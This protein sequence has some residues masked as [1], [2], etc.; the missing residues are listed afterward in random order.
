MSTPRPVR[1]SRPPRRSFRRVESRL[2]CESLEGRIV[3]TAGVSFDA[4]RGILA[5]MGSETADT[6]IV[7]NDGTNIVATLTTGTG[8]ITRSYR[9]SA[10]KSIAFTGLGGDDSFINNTA[11]PSTAS[12]GR[13]NDSLR[14][15]SG[16]DNLIGGEG[17]D[18]IQGNKGDDVLQGA[19]GNDT[20]IG[21]AGADRMFGGVGDDT[22]DG[23]IGDDDV[24]GGD[25]ADR[26]AGATG[27]DRLNGGRGDDWLDG[28]AGN[29]TG[30]GDEGNDVVRGGQGDDSLYGGLDNDAL[31]GD[32]GIDTVE[33]EAGDDRLDGG[34]GDDRLVGGV[35][36]DACV[37]VEDGFDDWDGT[38]QEDSDGDR[39]GGAVL[40]GA[41][42]FDAAGLAGIT[43]TVLDKKDR[44]DYSV[45][46]PADGQL[47][48]ELL[49]G[50]DGTWAKLVLYDGLGREVIEL[51]PTSRPRTSAVVAV[52]ANA[53]YTVQMRTP[54]K[55]AA[56][57]SVNL[58]VA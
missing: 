38:E 24:V 14:G 32:D 3:L 44:K 20:V 37:D 58:K 11:V 33:G 4:T 23:G 36:E 48:L 25:G 8:S 9:V 39:H 16:N 55:S 40:A 50:G 2:H 43:G 56:S 19:L 57:Y 15:G 13:G 27:D 7:R 22:L 51:D 29:D 52:V 46:I 42:V 10:V 34:V 31:Y 53:T 21:G 30:R 35:G 28:G 12:G 26:M 41:A 49:Q 18:K 6:A 47:T 17:D 54:D 5:I 1:S 45:T